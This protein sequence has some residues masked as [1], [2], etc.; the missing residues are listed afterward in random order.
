MVSR[1]STPGAKPVP[2]RLNVLLIAGRRS[3]AAAHAG[4]EGWA[5]VDVAACV[6]LADGAA[7]A[8]SVAGGGMAADMIVDGAGPR[9]HAA[10]RI[11]TVTD[12]QM[13]TL[14]GRCRRII[15]WLTA[16][17]GTEMTMPP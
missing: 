6:G 17:Y 2:V 16:A 1:T 8:G 7:L 15:T 4:G 13:H 5:W 3:T 11:I 10:T 9:E 14:R 12:C